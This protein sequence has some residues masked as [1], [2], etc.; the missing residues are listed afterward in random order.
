M[1]SATT[2][3]NAPG[4]LARYE[5]RR[6]EGLAAQVAPES[7]E[8]PFMARARERAAIRALAELQ[9]GDGP[10]GRTM[11]Y[12]DET[13]A[14]RELQYPDSFRQRL[15]DSVEVRLI[16][17]GQT[18]GYISDGALTALGRWQAHRKGADLAKGIREGMTVKFPHAPTARAKETAEGVRG[19]VQSTL[20][21]YG[22]SG[23]TLEDP[24]PN[25][26]FNN[27]QVY[28]GEGREMDVT[29]AF[30]EFANLRESYQKTGAGDRPGW[31]VEM[32]RF[33]QIQ[34]GGGDPI[35][36]WLTQPMQ[37][38][39]PSALVV[40]RHWKGIVAMAKQCDANTKVYVCGHSGPIRAVATSAVGHD[41]GE[42]H[43]T[44]DVRIKVY[45][46]YEH[47]VVTYRGRGLEIEIP[48]AVTPSWYA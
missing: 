22:I 25:N 8:P 44:E 4:Y 30:M 16:R 18:Q 7:S 10:P 21:R 46:D 48:T 39:E 36:S 43:N 2:R 40:R 38:F 41:P 42:P 15:T 1:S 13:V 28:V 11:A 35:T 5:Q 12:A 31:M 45:N 47:A 27:F 20:A 3:D 6:I 14:P 9:T 33:F 34:N 17:H 29:A 37:Y 26:W 19:G 32:D 24:E 23:V